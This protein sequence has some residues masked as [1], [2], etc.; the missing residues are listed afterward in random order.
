[1]GSCRHT[2]MYGPWVATVYDDTFIDSPAL[3]Y[4]LN[5]QYVIAQVS[6]V[7]A[8]SFQFIRHLNLEY[9]SLHDKEFISLEEPQIHSRT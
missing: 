2:L 8:I 3:R 7:D 6:V 5:V 9:C 4:N 1:M